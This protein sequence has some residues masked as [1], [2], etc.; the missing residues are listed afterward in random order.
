VGKRA[1]KGGIAN[2]AL[3]A[4]QKVIE[5][6]HPF[7]RDLANAVYQQARYWDAA[8]GPP[9]LAPVTVSAELAAP[10]IAAASGI[11]DSREN[12][13]DIAVLLVMRFMNDLVDI[14]ADVLAAFRSDRE[15]RRREAIERAV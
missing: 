1:R 9:L 6:Q 4:A 10:A 7:A 15:A 8:S 12:L 5:E 2:S 3:R 13:E 14:D 11:P